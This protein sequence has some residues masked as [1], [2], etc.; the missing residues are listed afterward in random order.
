MVKSASFLKYEASVNQRSTQIKVC[1]I[2][3]L[4][5]ALNA[6]QCGVEAIGFIFYPPSPRNLT[7]EQARV[8]R[9]KL[10][11]SV[12]SIAVVVDPDDNLLTGIVD[13]VQPD[14]IQFHGNEPQERCME[15]GLPFYKAFRVNRDVPIA[16]MTENYSE[17][18][19]IL[20]DAYVPDQVGGTGKTF[21]WDLVP[22]LSL[23][24]ILAG[25]LHSGNVAEA[26]RQLQPRAVDVST[27]VEDTPGIKNDEAVRDFVEAVRSADEAARLEGQE[28]LA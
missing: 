19:A 17:A 2:T 27:G 20:L 25:G 21:A 6:V 8:I 24:V 14:Y 4:N 12:S 5:D 11:P 7:C 28:A 16:R 15:T 13:T 10:P 1:G 23:P 9:E 18:K 3:R 22:S 26:I